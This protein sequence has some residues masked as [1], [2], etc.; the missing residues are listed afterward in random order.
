MG[1][2]EYASVSTMEQVVRGATVNLEDSNP[3]E[4]LLSVNILD[5]NQE[6]SLNL[7]ISENTWG[8]LSSISK[9]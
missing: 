3:E 8:H 5:Y 6:Q 7:Q 9:G 2:H 1:H 4:R